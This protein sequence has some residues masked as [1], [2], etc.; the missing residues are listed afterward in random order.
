[1]NLKSTQKGRKYQRELNSNPYT[2]GVTGVDGNVAIRALTEEELAYLEKF[3]N[4]FVEGNFERD[5]EGNV[6]ENNLHYNL[7][8]ES[9]ERVKVIKE[10][11]KEL[12]VK[13]RETNDYRTM[14]DR[15]AYWKYK[16]NL[17]KEREKLKDQLNEINIVGNINGSKYARRNDVMAYTGVG[18]KTVHVLDHFNTNKEVDSEHKLFEYIES[19]KT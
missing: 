9:E 4:E 19:S 6:N 3:N 11:I 2:K 15:K 8:N 10:Q 12:G 16:K 5:D 14:H 17:Y 1:M 18:E 13:L 7:I